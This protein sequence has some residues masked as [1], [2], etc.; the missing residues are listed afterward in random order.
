MAAPMCVEHGQKHG[1]LFSIPLKII[2][3]QKDHVA[4]PFFAPLF[5]IHKRVERWCSPFFQ[6]CTF[7]Q[8]HHFFLLFSLLS[9][10]SHHFDDAVG[11]KFADSF[12][13][14]TTTRCGALGPNTPSSIWWC[15]WWCHWCHWC[16]WCK[17][18]TERNGQT[19]VSSCQNAHSKTT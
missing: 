2:V 5:F 10:I 6:K 14:T 13:C 12:L 15:N 7:R 11:Q 8:G 18:V 17:N 1:C 9:E 19:S 4:A 3:V 16:H